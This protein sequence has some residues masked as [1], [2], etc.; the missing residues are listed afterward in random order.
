[1]SL[2]LPTA[3]TPL[4]SRSRTGVAVVSL[5]AL[6]LLIALLTGWAA[7]TLD[8]ATLDQAYALPFTT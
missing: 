4:R 7:S 2:A 5:A 8:P 1:M 3:S 6:F